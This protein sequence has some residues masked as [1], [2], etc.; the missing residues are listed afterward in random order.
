[1]NQQ[2]RC[3]VI[4]AKPF[5]M[6]FAK[7]LAFSFAFSFALFSFQATANG[8]NSGFNSSA[9]QTS[10]TTVSANSK[11]S[12]STNQ[13][14]PSEFNPAQFKQY[15]EQLN[16]ILRT[17]RDQEKEF[18][19]EV[20]SRVRAGALPSRLV[21]TSYQWIRNKRPNTNYP[22]LYFEKVLRLQAEKLKMKDAVPAFDYSVYKSVGQRAPGQFGS[23]GQLTEAQ[24]ESITRT[25][26]GRTPGQRR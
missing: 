16:A 1:M 26:N 10:N 5:A 15:E 17:R 23:A 20:V 6:S 7:Q 22:F 21:E 4:L 14:N 12:N 2:I 24:R 8:Q 25:A 19:A 13:Y 9:T 18:I 11:S 3:K